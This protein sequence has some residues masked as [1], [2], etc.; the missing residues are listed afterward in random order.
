M[1]Q[2]ILDPECTTC[3]REEHERLACLTRRYPAFGS[4]K[5]FPKLRATGP[6]TPMFEIDREMGKVRASFDWVT[7]VPRILLA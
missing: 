2:E 7:I 6:I 3:V 5:S 1:A 4:R